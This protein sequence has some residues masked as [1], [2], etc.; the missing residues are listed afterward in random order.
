M[1]RNVAVELCACFG[2]RFPRYVHI[3][4][5]FSEFRFVTTDLVSNCFKR[6]YGRHIDPNVGAQTRLQH[7]PRFTWA[8]PSLRWL[9]PGTSIPLRLYCFGI[10]NVSSRCSN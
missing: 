7:D 5:S 8:L 2:K 1:R 4:N 10:R 9:H 3:M 6:L